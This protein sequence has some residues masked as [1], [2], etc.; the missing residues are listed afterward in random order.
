MKYKSTNRVVVVVE[1]T[2]VIAVA[3][4]AVEF[5]DAYADVCTGAS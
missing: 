4:M 2:F 3:V 1:A 5:V